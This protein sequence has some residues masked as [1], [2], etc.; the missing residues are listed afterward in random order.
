MAREDTTISGE[1]GYVSSSES[2][3]TV[4]KSHFLKPSLKLILATGSLGSIHCLSGQSIYDAVMKDWKITRTPLRLRHRLPWSFLLC[5]AGGMD[6][7]KV[8]SYKNLAE[9]LRAVLVR[10]SDPISIS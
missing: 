1:V 6:E 7:Y 8:L 9:P 3:A 10:L 2:S 5:V 4:E